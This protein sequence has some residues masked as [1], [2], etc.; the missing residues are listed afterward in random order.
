MKLFSTRVLIII[1]P[2]GLLEYG[3]CSSTVYIIFFFLKQLNAIWFS[4]AFKI[5][6]K[7]SLCPNTEHH[8]VV[9]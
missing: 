3:K 7:T 2:Q 5:R 9:N 1:Y 6:S 8:T 4:R